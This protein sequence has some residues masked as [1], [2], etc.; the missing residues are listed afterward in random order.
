VN[1][2][3]QRLALKFLWLQEQGSKAIHA[4]LRGTLKD[5]AVSLPTVKRWLR[6]FREGNTSCKGRNIAG[7]P[8][9]ILGDVLSKFVSKYP[10]GLVK[11]IASDFDIS[12]STVKH[13]RARELGLRKFTRKWVPHSLSDR[14]KNEWVT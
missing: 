3:E 5:L 14:Q 11:N 8:L 4:H 1:E 10:F 9:A 13:L 7:R 6:H 2:Q 12:V